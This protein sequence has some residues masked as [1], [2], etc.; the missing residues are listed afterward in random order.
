MSLAIDVDTVTH[1]LLADGWH[2]V[3]GTSFALDAYEYMYQGEAVL[4][5]GQVAGAP[6]TGAEW[7]DPNG[8]RIACPLTAILSGQC[9]FHGWGFP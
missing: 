1:V 8:T 6:S 2:T 3:K 5:G 9:S 7:A 4:G